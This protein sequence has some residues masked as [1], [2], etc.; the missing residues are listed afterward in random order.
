[1]PGAPLQQTLYT[2]LMPFILVG[3]LE[4]IGCV[5]WLIVYFTPRYDLS[6]QEHSAHSDLSIQSSLSQRLLLLIQTG[7]SR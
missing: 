7:F 5:H 2:L 3:L 1:M 6:S 4:L